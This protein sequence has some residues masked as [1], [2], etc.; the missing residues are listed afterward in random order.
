MLKSRVAVI[1]G[2]LATSLAGCASAPNAL[3]P[4]APT[5]ILADLC[6]FPSDLTPEQMETIAN[7][8]DAASDDP[9]IGLLAVEWERLDA[10]AR[11]CR[12]RP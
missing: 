3:G 8:L 9:G 5:V 10:E 7:A 6:P 1:A 11:A 2:A 12:R 4:V